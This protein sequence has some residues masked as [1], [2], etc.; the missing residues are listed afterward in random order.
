MATNIN[1][2][3]LT[4]VNRMREIMGMNVINEGIDDI[5]K[6]LLGVSDDAAQSIVKGNADELG[7]YSSKLKSLVGGTGSISDITNYL[8]RQGVGTSDDAIA[9]W[10]KTQPEIM[11]QIAR[12][13]DNIMKQAS[14]IVFGRLKLSSI[15]DSKS[16]DIIDDLLTTPLN[17]NYVDPMITAID[18]ALTALR[19]ARSRGTN[20][21]VEDLIKQL[22]D[23]RKIAENYKSNLNNS[24]AGS[25]GSQRTFAP[26]PVDNTSDLGDDFDSVMQRFATENPTIFREFRSKIENL[27]LKPK[28]KRQMLLSFGDYGNWTSRQLATE[29]EKV[30][31]AMNK[32]DAAKW[33]WL[34]KSLYSIQTGEISIPK[35]SLWV[36]GAGLSLLAL[37]LAGKYGWFAYELG[38]EGVKELRD[39]TGL[40]K[41]EPSGNNSGDEYSTE[42]GL[43]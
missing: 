12:S 1:G 21:D 36:G 15:I 4:E 22:E 19:S 8:S 25:G 17:K 33:S 14:Q 7:Q 28:V 39:A 13:S 18:D 9:A 26:P 10:I 30:L 23:K 27:N 40:D 5:I 42:G 16:I 31:V 38:D 11:D 2:I 41:S 20:P 32:L 29:A 37:I 3:L 24:S 34:K 6:K 35:I 43:N